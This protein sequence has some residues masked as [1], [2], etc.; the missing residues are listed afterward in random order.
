MFILLSQWITT[1]LPKFRILLRNICS[2]IIYSLRLNMCLGKLNWL[3][4]RVVVA[5]SLP[6]N[7]LRWNNIEI[8]NILHKFSSWYCEY[9]EPNY[10]EDHSTRPAAVSTRPIENNCSKGRENFQPSSRVGGIIEKFYLRF[11]SK[12]WTTICPFLF[13]ADSWPATFF[14]RPGPPITY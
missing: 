7:H 5:R 9:S 12:K 6:K 2:L 11:Q 13:W 10:L 1:Q 8:P 14:Y 4:K 3:S